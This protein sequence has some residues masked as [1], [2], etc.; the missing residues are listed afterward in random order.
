MDERRN[1]RRQDYGESFSFPI[2][3]D[4]VAV[5]APYMSLSVRYVRQMRGISVSDE[6][7][8]ALSSPDGDD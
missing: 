2:K 5:F 1:N 6:A 4:Q 8:K 7:P 3:S